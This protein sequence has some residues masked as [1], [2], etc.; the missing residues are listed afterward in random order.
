MKLHTP[1]GER[2]TADNL[3]T[4]D[5]DSIAAWDAGAA[6]LLG[7]AGRSL[8]APAAIVTSS[9]EIDTLAALPYGTP[10]LAVYLPDD[11]GGSAAWMARVRPAVV[12]WTAA[13]G[14]TRDQC[15]AWTLDGIT[16][17]ALATP[18]R[19]SIVR[20]YQ[21]GGAPLV[22]MMCTR[23]SVAF[24]S[25]KADDELMQ[26]LASPGWNLYGDADEEC[27]PIVLLQPRRFQR[28]KVFR[29]QPPL[30]GCPF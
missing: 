13:E 22:V 8:T 17:L 7:W 3:W 14:R 21:E 18:M 9:E 11:Y 15:F 6:R 5:A 28:A 27:N 20:Q 25:F 1:T 24:T 26:D 23:G 30:D 2:Q 10:V 12:N 19:D 29:L 16:Y 4:D